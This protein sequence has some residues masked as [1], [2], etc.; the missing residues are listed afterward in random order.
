[1]VSKNSKE[2]GFSLIEV[3]IALIVISLIMTP[4]IYAY[5]IHIETTKSVITSARAD[6]IRS[7]LLKFFEKN[8][9][10]PTPAHPNVAQGTPGFGV[11]SLIG[12]GWPACTA[13]PTVPTVVCRTA[14]TGFGAAPAA[15]NGILIG[16]VPIAALGLPYKLMLDGYGN[17]LT[18][19]VSENLTTTANFADDRGAVRILDQAGTPSQAHFAVISHG[20]TGMGAFTLAGRQSAA[21]NTLTP[22][23]PADSQNC[24]ND[25]I[26]LSNQTGGVEVRI[27]EGNNA[28]FFDDDIAF[29]NTTSFGIWSYI[30]NSAL[31]MQSRNLGNIKIGCAPGVDCRPLA[32]LDVEGNVQATEVQTSRICNTN[33]WWCVSAPTSVNTPFRQDGYANGWFSPDMVTGSPASAPSAPAVPPADDSR[34]GVSGSGIGCYSNYGLRGIRGFDEYCAGRSSSPHFTASTNGVNCSVGQFVIGISITG[35]NSFNLICGP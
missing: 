35:T 25:G 22:P 18:Y 21:C 15:T 27:S 8:G 4:L 14:N 30:P 33:S 5:N 32:K 24:N 17:R 34:E 1:M 9:F 19:A 31:N 10:Y 26:F 23:V 11:P 2:S 7:A 3:S 12:G 29:I 20:K 16:S 13:P 6:G 28:N